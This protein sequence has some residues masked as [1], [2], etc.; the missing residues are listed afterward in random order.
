MRRAREPSPAGCATQ[1]GSGRLGRVPPS[2]RRRASPS[3]PGRHSEHAVGPARSPASKNG[4]KRRPD[5]KAART[6]GRLASKTPGR[7]FRTACHIAPRGPRSAE[8]DP[9]PSSGRHFWPFWRCVL[10]GGRSPHARSSPERAAG[11]RARGASKAGRTTRAKSGGK[12]AM[13]ERSTARDRA[14]QEGPSEHRVHQG[15][16]GRARSGPA[17][18]AARVPGCSRSRRTPPARMPPATPRLAPAAQPW[19]GFDTPSVP[20]GSPRT[21]AR[22]RHLAPRR[23]A[24]HALLGGRSPG[25][26][27]AWPARRAAPRPPSQSRHRSIVA[28]ARP[29]RARH[30]TPRRP[31]GAGPTPTRLERIRPP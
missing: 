28:R 16:E 31:C 18:Q 6:L 25:P 27:D 23:P 19:P 22:A 24:T 26:P 9:I 5:D 2:A 30:P 11:R 20:L 10:H 21:S 4:Q 17:P 7:D 14:R 3:P 29:P 13:R 15:H 1:R 8:N 12:Q